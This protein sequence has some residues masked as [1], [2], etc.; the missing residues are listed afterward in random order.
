MSQNAPQVG[1]PSYGHS[2]DRWLGG[3]CGYYDITHTDL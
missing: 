2:E 3:L 1:D